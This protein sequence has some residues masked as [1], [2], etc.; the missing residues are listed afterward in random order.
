[1]TAPTM[2]RVLDL[3]A[4]DA[5]CY[6][7][8]RRGDVPYFGIEKVSRSR[9]TIRANDKM[10]WTEVVFPL[11]PSADGP[12]VVLDPLRFLCAPEYVERARALFAPLLEG[13]L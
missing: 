2:P 9:V 13:T 4:L 6:A 8:F 7:S 5:F 10:R 12:R 11:Y 3:S 1:M